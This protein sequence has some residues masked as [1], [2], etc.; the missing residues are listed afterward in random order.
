[1]STSD[2]LDSKFIEHCFD[3]LEKTRRDK[4]YEEQQATPKRSDRPE[5]FYD[6]YAKELK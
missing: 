6:M 5:E 3:L 2:I 1:M 4:E